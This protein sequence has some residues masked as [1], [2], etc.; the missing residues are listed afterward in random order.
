MLLQMLSQNGG[1]NPIRDAAPSAQQPG[2]GPQMV[3]GLTPDQRNMFSMFDL[4]ITQGNQLS[5]TLKTMR[6]QEAANAVDACLVKI[7]KLKIDIERDL[8]EEAI[9]SALANAVSPQQA[10]TR[11]V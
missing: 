5:D 4:F 1:Q 6:E 8:K 9:D 7:T 3:D 2:S 11:Q 10:Q